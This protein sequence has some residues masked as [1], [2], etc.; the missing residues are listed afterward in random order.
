MTRV[1]ARTQQ[2]GMSA[3]CSRFSSANII[4][5]IREAQ[6]GDWPRRTAETMPKLN[7]T[8]TSVSGRLKRKQLGQQGRCSVCLSQCHCLMRQGPLCALGNDLATV[9]HPAR[10]H[11]CSGCNLTGYFGQLLPWGVWETD[12]PQVKALVNMLP[13][14]SRRE[15]LVWRAGSQRGGS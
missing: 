15:E 11:P 1:H 8:V 5:W 4:I 3:N 9:W 7:I 12:A 10:H 13:Q 14:P 2:A 6:S